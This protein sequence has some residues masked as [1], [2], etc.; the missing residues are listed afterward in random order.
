MQPK[1]EGADS[2]TMCGNPRLEKKCFGCGG[3][4]TCYYTGAQLYVDVQAFILVQLSWVFSPWAE[5]QHRMIRIVFSCQSFN[6]ENFLTLAKFRLSC[7]IWIYVLHLRWGRNFKQLR[8]Y[9]HVGFCIY[10]GWQQL[11]LLLCHFL[12]NRP[13]GIWLQWNLM[14]LY[15]PVSSNTVL[16]SR[17]M[18]VSCWGITLLL[19]CQT[20]SKVQR[21]TEGVWQWR[22]RQVCSESCEPDTVTDMLP[23]SREK[24]S[25]PSD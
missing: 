11:V 14:Y 23:L 5:K 4:K 24:P 9:V 8:A 1:E 22:C 2:D 16:H 12:K 15:W 21:A 18:C 10:T 20:Y 13:S 17:L 3:S 19:E 6:V 7:K 25:L